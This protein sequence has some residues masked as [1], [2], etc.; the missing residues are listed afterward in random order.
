MLALSLRTISDLVFSAF[1]EH[2][3]EQSNHMKNMSPQTMSLIL[4]IAAV[5][6]GLLS[7]KFILAQPGVAL[8]LAYFSAMVLL[9]RAFVEWKRPENQLVWSLVWGAVIAVIF[10]LIFPVWGKLKL[11]IIPLLVAAPILLNAIVPMI[12]VAL[13]LTRQR[14]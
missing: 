5:S 4:F 13:R 3:T 10:A 14:S 1:R 11:P 8:G 2:L 7:C 9:L 6:A 12:K